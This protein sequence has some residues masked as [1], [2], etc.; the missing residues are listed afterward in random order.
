[1]ISNLRSKRLSILRKDSSYSFSGLRKQNGC[2]KF[3]KNS[4]MSSPRLVEDDVK[5]AGKQPKGSSSAN[6]VQVINN[7]P[8]LMLMSSEG[9]EVSG[10]NSKIS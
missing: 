8:N 1:M 2:V 5:Y 3:D 7:S 4:E 6:L 10:K 9:N